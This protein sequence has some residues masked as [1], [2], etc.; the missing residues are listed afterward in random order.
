MNSHCELTGIIWWLEVRPPWFHL[1]W[2]IRI[3]PRLRNHNLRFLKYE[4]VDIIWAP[5]YLTSTNHDVVTLNSQREFT[6]GHHCG[7]T[8]R[9]TMW[10][11]CDA[12][13]MFWCEFTL[14]GHCDHIMTSVCEVTMSSICNYTFVSQLP[15][16]LNSYCEV[17]V[18]PRC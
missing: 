9:V 5:A 17:F 1:K 14:W 12:T 8:V 15:H 7:I 18:I 16:T 11:H 2:F 6:S 4:W 10:G 13:R 3:R